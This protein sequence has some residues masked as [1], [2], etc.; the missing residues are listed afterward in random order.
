MG[1]AL[2]ACSLSATLNYL[3]FD[4]ISFRISCSCSP[5]LV[6][7]QAAEKKSIRSGMAVMLR[8]ASTLVFALGLMEMAYAMRWSGPQVTP[9]GLMAMNG[10]TP[11]PTQAPG[12]DGLPRELRKRAAGEYIYP[13]PPN[14]C[15]FVSGDY[16]MIDDDFGPTELI[17]P[18]DTLLSCSTDYT[19]AFSQ[20]VFGCCTGPAEECGIFTACVDQIFCDENCPADTKVLKWY[21]GEFGIN[22]LFI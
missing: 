1:F 6:C 19:C 10:V 3:D 22:I 18:V 4:P 5:Y 20:R 8:P 14:W 15:G 13:P 7:G 12:W 11:R 9:A 16:G 17:K 2:V 21:C